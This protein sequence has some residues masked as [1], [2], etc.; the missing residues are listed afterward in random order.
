[1]T[2]STAADLVDVSIQRVFKKA[3]N[4]GVPGEIVKLYNEESTEDYYDKDSSLS[5][6]GEAARLVE[7]A[8]ITS[9]SPVQGFDRTYTW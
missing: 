5:G 8:I 1:M 2:L 9:E 4:L 7:N 3:S 6:F